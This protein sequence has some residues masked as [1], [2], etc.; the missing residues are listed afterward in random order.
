MGVWGVWL[1]SLILLLLLLL[2]A[3]DPEQN[4]TNRTAMNI[5]LQCGY[6]LLQIVSKTC[7]YKCS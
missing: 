4:K 5:L 6:N 3:Y 7:Q 1:D 2:F